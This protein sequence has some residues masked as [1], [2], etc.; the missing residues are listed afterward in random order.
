MKKNKIVFQ[1][2]TYE[3]WLRKEEVA[4]GSSIQKVTG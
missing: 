2:D 1:S 3:I 4:D